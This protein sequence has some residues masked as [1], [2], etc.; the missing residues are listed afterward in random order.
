MSSS[1]T[2]LS[3]ADPLIIT[4]DG[5]AGSGKSTIARQLAKRLGLDFLDTGAMYRGLAAKAATAIVSEL[6]T[7]DGIAEVRAHMHPDNVAIIDVA[8]KIRLSDRGIVA[9]YPQFLA[10]FDP[11]WD[12][13]AE[14]IAEVKPSLDLV[15]R[16]LS[17]I[18]DP[19]AI[20]FG[21]EAPAALR[22]M[23]IEACEPPDTDRL[24]TPKPYPELLLSAIEG[25]AATL[26][27][28]M[29][30]MQQTIFRNSL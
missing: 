12:G 3:A 9:S 30:P 18:M 2:I 26:G 14:W 20:F 15:I 23:L 7:V 11:N 25:D 16:S 27:A 13:V 19:N 28:A 21:G 17:A 1:Q 5:P 24:G 8:R 4:I 10:E 22:M 6:L 29:L